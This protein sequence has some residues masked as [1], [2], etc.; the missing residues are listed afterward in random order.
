MK[1][2]EIFRYKLYNPSKGGGYPASGLDFYL[3]G[4]PREEIKYHLFEPRD[5]NLF[6]EKKNTQFCSSLKKTLDQCVL[7]WGVSRSTAEK[8]TRAFLFLEKTC[9]RW[10]RLPPNV[11]IFGKRLVIDQLIGHTYHFVLCRSRL[12]FGFPHTNSIY[13]FFSRDFIESSKVKNLARTILHEMVHIYQRFGKGAA[14]LEKLCK[15][16]G[17]S[18][19]SP[20]DE[21][22]K[23]Y[24]LSSK[25]IFLNNPD[26]YRHGEY[27]Y[28]STEGTFIFKLVLHKEKNKVTRVAFRINVGAD[29][30][31]GTLQQNNPVHF[32]PRTA[33]ISHQYEH[34]YEIIACFWADNIITYSR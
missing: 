33:T 4:M 28:A 3:H 29:A 34:P 12:E 26:V 1:N 17:Y 31:L 27:Y 8:F 25:Y 10:M 5:I 23:K 9:A 15:E 13:I 2:M 7:D 14:L 32:I 11:E 18:R 24:S 22:Q 6:K 21:Q 16:L 30:G 20:G 19:L